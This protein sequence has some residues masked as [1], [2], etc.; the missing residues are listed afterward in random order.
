MRRPATS[1]LAVT[2]NGVERLRRWRDEDRGVPPAVA[3]LRATLAHVE[4]A[5][6]LLRLPVHPELLLPGGAPTGAVTSLLADFGLTSSV[7]AS[8]PD[9]RGVTTV[10][11]TVDHL[12]PPPAGGA[13]FAECRA[14]PYDQGRPQHATGVLYEEGGRHLAAASGWFLPA[15]AEAQSADRASLVE[16]SPADHLLDLLGIGP[17]PSFE[18]VARDAL[19][20]ALGSLHGGIGALASQLAAEAALG[21]TVRPLTSAFSYL[22]PTP[23]DG[24][25]TMTGSV[26]RQGRRTG[27]SSATVVGPGGTLVLQAS[28]VAAL[29]R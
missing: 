5:K 1:L 24:S 21:P 3:R 4:P 17:G 22:R 15:P 18:L 2:E 12:S 11:M 29:D 13:L 26:V 23:R 7:I 19:S 16:E 14:S 9:L 8:L 25:V 6:T 20:N 27:L 10:S 28:L